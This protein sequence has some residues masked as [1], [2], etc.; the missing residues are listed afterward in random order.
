MRRRE[1][2][3]KLGWRWRRNPLRRRTDVIESWLMLLSVVLLCL[4]PLAGWWAGQSVN[5]GLQRVAR[6][7]RAERRLV[8][9]T[10]EPAKTTKT[11][12]EPAAAESVRNSDPRGDDVLRWTAPGGRVHSTVVPSDLQIWDQDKVMV[13]I[14]GKGRLAPP[15]LDP[16]TA[17]THAVLAGVAAASGAAGLVLISRQV[18]MWRL[19]R[20][21][22]ASWEREWARV[23]QDWGRTGAGG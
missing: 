13:W 5:S 11:T 7:E 9:A 4:V 23:G 15:P 2:L 1:R 17:S 20:R 21:R 18:L 22:I 10:V 16:A 14:D 6:E 8:T 12:D 19:M 3:T